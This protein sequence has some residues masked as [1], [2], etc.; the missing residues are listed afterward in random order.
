M[1]HPVTAPSVPVDS[2]RRGRMPRSPVRRRPRWRPA[3]MAAALLSCAAPSASTAP[4]TTEGRPPAHG[5]AP[6]YISDCADNVVLRLPA[7]VTASGPTRPTGMALDSSGD[8]HIADSFHDRV[9]EVPVRRG[10]RTLP[11]AG[12]S[13]PAG[14]AVPS[15]RDAY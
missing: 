5:G 3:A 7:T 4:G 1:S 9:V 13:T 6:L 11:V 14:L 12:L 10:Q 2:G 8:L 15:G